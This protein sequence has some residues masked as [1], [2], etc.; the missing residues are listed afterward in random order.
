[1]QNIGT[2]S[3]HLSV[4]PGLQSLLGQPVVHLRAGRSPRAAQ[5]DTIVGWG[6]R[7]TTRKPRLIARREALPFIALEDGFL[8]SFGTG[9]AYP[10]LSLVVDP[11][12]IYYAADRASTLEC[13]LQSDQDL[14]TGAG[15]DY[16]QARAQFV[17]LGL[18]KYN[19]APDL[20]TLPGPADRRRVLVVDQTVGD[21]SV[22]YGLANETSFAQMLQAA[23]DEN[24]DALIF[25]K[26][27][28]EVSGGAKKGFLS[29]TQQDERTFLLRDPAS[30]ASL[31]RQI[32][33]VYVVTS[34]MGFEA[35]LHGLKV[36]CFGMPWYAGWG[37]TH[38]RLKCERRKRQRSV[39]ELFAAAY[40]H[41]TRYLN[42]ETLERGNI[43]DVMK[44]LT[45]QRHMHQALTGRTIAVGYRRWKAE[46]VRPFLSTDPTRVHFVANARAAEALFPTP[47][48]RLVVWGASPDEAI[49]ELSQ[50]SGA[51]LL[52]M[53][54]GFVRSVGLG[55]DFVPPGAL[56]LDRRGLYF[57][58]RQ[59]HDLE[60]LLNNRSFTGADIERARRVRQLIVDNAL[61]KYNIEPTYPAKWADGNR[62]TI[63]VP[64]QVE[65]DASIR[66]GCGD[67]RDNL[68]L[69]R[70]ARSA[71]PN[72]FIVYKPHPDVLVRNRHG[73][74][75]TQEALHFA[76]HIETQVS[77]VSCIESASEIHTMTSLSGFDAL[78]RNKRVVTYGSPFYAGWGLTTDHRPPLRRTRRLEL[79]Q[80]IAGV[81]LHYPL[82]WD[83]TLNGYTTCEGA[84]HR[85]I[86]Q[87]SKLVHNKDFLGVRKSYVQR[88]CYKLRL[89]ARAKFLVTR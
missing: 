65:D 5:V 61:T 48:D 13:L 46:N 88:Q 75:H 27:H 31:F 49:V 64:G 78:I 41:Y 52:R 53:E 35:L 43:F 71:N 62:H 58:A 33:Q 70:A 7:P 40:L 50:Q 3:R 82:Y 39:D 55:S 12:G 29:N 57:D 44:W 23:K 30:P 1:M 18:S 51:S 69:L 87:K 8:R 20:Q 67:V 56:V 76:D 68:S 84:L 11:I 89:W 86:Q 32:D 24:P 72:A 77:I 26:T 47:E 15:A 59:T 21:A 25:V 14:L 60:L 66:F 79:D 80:L 38:D 74:V 63:L 22:E 37:A 54:D 16:V 9:A 34:H 85:I 36:T 10:T 28:P 4:L 17:C 2:Y 19:L 45:L 81:M 42:P 73:N 6:L 83:W